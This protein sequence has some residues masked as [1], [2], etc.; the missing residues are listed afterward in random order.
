M[1]VGE[2]ISGQV[3][4]DVARRRRRI[5]EILVDSGKLQSAQVEAILGV[6]RERGVRFG[7]AAIQLDLLTYQDVEFA[8]SS[9]LSDSY[10][11]RGAGPPGKDLVAVHAPSGSKAEAFRSIRSQ[12]IL[13][14]F[15][16][17]PSHKALAVVSAE[18]NDGRSFI[19]ANLAVVLA[20]MG[21]QT[22]LVDADLRNPAQQRLFNLGNIAGLSEVLQ[23]HCGLEAISRI[24]SQQA[25]FVL[26]AGTVPANASDLL[27]GSHF[28]RLMHELISI[29]D[30]VVVDTPPAFGCSDA[31]SVVAAAGAAIVVARENSSRIAQ[32]RTVLE[33]VADTKANI[34]GAVLNNL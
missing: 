26:S 22:L 2:I 32:V 18:R 7:D 13:R 20:Q 9:Q 11:S 5:G 29:F 27:A 14:W 19:A 23:G 8:L 28:V 34:V 25:L 12:L 33:G 30:F 17:E 15:D 24:A 16:G 3:H 4:G 6:Q 10:P 21:K 31:Q 1:P